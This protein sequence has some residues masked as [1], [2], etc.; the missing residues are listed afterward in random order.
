MAKQT[1]L[2]T[3]LP[4][5]RVEEGPL[6]GR[7]RISIVASPRL[8][9]QAPDE[10]VLKAFPEWVNWPKTLGYVK[11]QLAIGPDSVDLEPISMS[12]PDLWDKLFQE[13]TPVSG[14]VFK[15][16]SKVNLRSFSVRNVLGTLR[17]HYKNL[18]IQSTGTPPTLLPWKNAHPVLK[19]MLRD[20]G[21]NLERPFNRFFEDDNKDGIE[22]QLQN[23]VFGPGSIFSAEAVAAGADKHGNPVHGTMFPVRALPPDWHHPSGGGSA[24]SVM[25]QFSSAAEYAFYQADRFY[26]REP[27]T[28]DKI[29][30]LQGT[31]PEENQLRRPKL[32][33]IPQPPK[34]PDLDFH[35]IVASFGD[36][37]ELLRK[38]GLV[39]D[40]VLPSDSPIEQ[41]INAAP[42][43]TG[44]I[45]LE[46]SWGNAHDPADDS[47]PRTAWFCDSRRFTTKPRTSDHERGVL[48][49]QYADD[50]W[51]VNEKRSPFD[52]YQ[53]DVDGAALKT[54]DFVI[55]AQNL[56]GKSLSRG[57]DGQITYTTGNKQPV[58]A[59]RS[60]GLGV[61]YH[62][63]AVAVAQ[64]AA[65]AALKDAEVRAG[66]AASKNV[67]L[68]TEDVLRGYRVDVQTIK[69]GV[70][71]PWQSLCRRHGKYKLIKQ[72]EFIPIADDEG[73]VKGASSTSSAS[74]DANPD[75]H[76]L[77][78]T[79]FKWAGWSL[80]AQRPGKTLRATTD[81]AS[82]V[83][84]E[85]PEDVTDEVTTGGNGLS[86]QFEAVKKS[87]PRLRFGITYRFRAR[88]VDLA[89][90]SLAFDDKSLEKDDQVTRPINYWRFEPVDPP[91]LVHC[92]RTSEGESLERMV[93]RSDWNV[94]PKFLPIHPRFFCRNNLARL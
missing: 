23:S 73:Y 18:A 46:L 2:W 32:R 68:F 39:I 48:K 11:F 10:Q 52:V 82:G 67:D 61:S 4:N 3:A 19:G 93:I 80:V 5:G 53:V 33:N 40:C 37:P 64:S 85:T 26:R 35:Q 88:I 13:D 66:G 91:V 29:K 70:E 38:L 17:K 24:A 86:V 22:R 72:D 42:T 28:K 62:G 20:L 94:D 89:G 74:E 30:A 58:A 36:Y 41:A 92:N 75:D 69:D 56:V 57:A 1:I 78:E 60:G 87:L 21:T 31:Q 8:T 77:H 15:D 12:E 49:L 25:A 90:N 76:Y 79:M 14:F 9:P 16:M 27:L 59:L 55:T 34:V 50:R 44:F 81:A 84:G 54:V 83:Q 71:L 65:S 45:G 47:C 7:L 51:I 6:E 63:R 43:A